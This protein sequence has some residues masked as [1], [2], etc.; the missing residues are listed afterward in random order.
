MTSGAKPLVS[1]AIV[2]YNQKE[3]LKE[4]IESCLAQDYPYIE[5][6]VADD[7]S[8]DG[9]HELLNEYDKTYPGK[10]VLCLA[11]KNKGITANS[12]AA[13]FACNGKYI[14]WMGGDDLMLPGKISMQVNYMEENPSCTICYHNLDVFDSDSNNTIHYYNEKKK[15][16]GDV[17]TSIRFGTF[18]GACSNLVRANK[19]PKHG[20]DNSLPVASDW[21][22]WVEALGNGGTINYI[23]EVLG[24][25]RRHDNNISRREN[26]ITQNELD[27]LMSCQIIISRFPQYFSDAMYVYSER[28]LTVRHKV[29]YLAC[30]WKSISLRPTLKAIGGL[31]VYLITFGKV[32]L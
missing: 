20:F 24:R 15:L 31:V 3:F 26:F 17:R 4:C 13:H 16:N 23:D 2:T 1:I 11:E 7:G 27:H 28:L 18:N 5:I 14:A 29:D 32:K 8:N 19:T 22:Y 25:Y 30:L 10:F 12:N 6:V 9:T 21:L